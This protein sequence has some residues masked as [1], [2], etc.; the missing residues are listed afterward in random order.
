MKTPLAPVDPW[1]IELI[2]V[3]HASHSSGERKSLTLDVERGLLLRLRKG[4]YVDRAAF[5]ELTPEEQHIVLMRAFA[6]ASPEPVVFSHWSA[7]VLHGLPVLRHRLRTVHVTTQRPGAR[8]EQG[9]TGHVF[10]IIDR[11]VV[12]FGP[13]RATGVARTVVD[14][15]GATQLEEGVITA[16][17][18]LQAGVPRSSSTSCSLLSW[19]EVRWTGR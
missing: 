14:I 15:A 13:L 9:V 1:R 16:D 8:G 5:E 4:V 7:A 12:T 3:L 11:E 18:A 17:G 2:A 6:V 19:S 10:G